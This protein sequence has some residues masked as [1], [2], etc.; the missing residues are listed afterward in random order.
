MAAVPGRLPA[1]H[2]GASWAHMHHTAAGQHTGAVQQDN[3]TAQQQ[4]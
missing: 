4:A 2:K 3:S 1:V